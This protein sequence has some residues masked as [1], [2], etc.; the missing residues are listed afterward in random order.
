MCA[1][2]GVAPIEFVDVAH[3]R[4]ASLTVDHLVS[5]E[6]DAPSMGDDPHVGRL[7]VRAGDAAVPLGVLVE[8]RPT[9][10]AVGQLAL[11]HLSGRCGYCQ[12]QGGAGRGDAPGDSDHR[13][14][15]DFME[16]WPIQPG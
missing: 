4:E 15:P 2:L 12:Q 13:G 16:P 9:L 6:G 14:P 3:G 1:G 8:H 11:D 5:A 10:Q 7:T